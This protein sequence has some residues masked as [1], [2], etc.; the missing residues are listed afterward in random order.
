MRHS[1]SLARGHVLPELDDSAAIAFRWPALGGRFKLL[2]CFALLCRLQARL[3]ARFC[4]AVEGLRNRGGAAHLA[5]KQD[6][7]LKV[8]A[9]VDHTQHVANADLARSLGRLPVGLNPAEF[10]G[11]R[12]QYPRLEEPGGPKPFI[13]SHGGH[14]LF[15][16]TV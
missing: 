16:Y 14:E 1:P 12:R 9:L 13:H 4:L 6:F 10:T 15:S 5:E 11:P 3:P 7:Y 2:R 8:A